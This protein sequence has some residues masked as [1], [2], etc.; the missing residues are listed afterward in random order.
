MCTAF[1]YWW[2][3]VQRLQETGTYAPDSSGSFVGGPWALGPKRLQWLTNITAGFEIAALLTRAL[4]FIL[5][6]LLRILI[7]PEPGGSLTLHSASPTLK[8]GPA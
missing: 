5:L 1:P 3:S 2:F 8:A 6:S 4:A 7:G